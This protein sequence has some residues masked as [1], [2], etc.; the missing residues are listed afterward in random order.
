MKVKASKKR[1]NPYIIPVMVILCVIPLI[2]HLK[3]YDTHLENYDYFGS[4]TFADFYL[5]HKAMCFIIV[6]VIMVGLIGAQCFIKH[7]KLEF[8]KLFIPLAGYA[9]LSFLSAV[10]SKTPGF[11]FTGIYEHFE[12]VWVLLGYAITVYYCCIFISTIIIY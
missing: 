7:Y 12:S 4:S 1:F 8:K 5:Y 10:F 9:G 3:E 11:S 2:V 6:N